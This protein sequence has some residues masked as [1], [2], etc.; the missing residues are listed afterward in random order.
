[1]EYQKIKAVFFDA[2]DTLFY[3]K[4]GLGNTYALA[5]KK[6][7]IDP[8]PNKLKN[9]F[10]KH[11]PAAPPLAFTN[12]ND[13]ER[14]ILEKKW[15]YEVVKNVYEDIGMFPEFD[16][17]FEDL[18]ELFRTNAWKIFPDTKDVLSYLK[19]KDYR[20]IVVSNFDSRVY[21]VC[22]SMEILDYFDDFVIS[23]EAGFAKPDIKIFKLALE[24][25]SLQPSQCVHIGDNYINDYISPITLGMNAVYLDRDM[26]YTNEESVTRIN[27]LSEILGLF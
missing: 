25:N 11:F 2:A 6:Y 7:G 23:S 9:S 10:S 27:N 18:F 13:K 19:N 16:S 5:A 17:Y 22:K 21:D 4:E 24:R 1:M 8:S 20:L 3:I 15:W 12:V 14:K 26:K